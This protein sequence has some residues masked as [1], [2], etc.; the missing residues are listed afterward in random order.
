MGVPYI[1]I[2]DPYHRRAHCYA[3]KSFIEAE[4]GVLKTSDPDIS[5]PLSAIFE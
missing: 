1:W 2:I 4:D 3:N 5:V